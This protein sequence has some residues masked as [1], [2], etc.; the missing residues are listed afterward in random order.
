MTETEL[1][2][3]LDAAGAARLRRHPDL[4]A[5]R[6]APR[7]TERLVSIYVDTE[8]H[9]LDRAG[10]ALRLRRI[11]RR[12]VQTVKSG[13]TA[14]GAGLYA[15]DE[16]ERPAPGGRLVLDGPDPTGVYASIAAAAGDAPLAPVFETRVARLSE[17]LAL[18]T[19]ADG[20]ASA[21]M[22]L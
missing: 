12:W 17:R 7:R 18:R 21:E 4:A 22:L 15:Q 6:A 11:S 1:K 5:L 13:R 20:G 19:H 16:D 2:I 14:G 3:T 8:G 9:A 10:I